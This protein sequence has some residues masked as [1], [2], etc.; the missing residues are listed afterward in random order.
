MPV[1]R[2]PYQR[3][4]FPSPIRLTSRDKRI[5]ETIHAFD[6]ML[7]P[8]RQIDR[9][10]FSG[11]GRSQPRARMRALFDNGYVQMPNPESIHQVPRSETIYWLDRK[12]AS[13]VA[14][15]QGK[16]SAQLKWRRKPR[17]SQIEHD[18]RVNDFR[19]AV[20]EDLSV[21][22]QIFSSKCGY[23]KASSL[24][25]LTGF[26]TRLQQARKHRERFDLMATSRLNTNPNLEETNHFPFCSK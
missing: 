7:E 8:S 14:G 16:S 25:N 20:R 24:Y 18:L 19:I 11:R 2:K 21:T 13:L 5:F 4:A 10:F 22:D 26:H 6:G 1:R 23:L 15:L 9:L 17:F 12:G 3:S